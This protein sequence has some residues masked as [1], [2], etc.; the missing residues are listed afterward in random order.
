MR[1]FYDRASTLAKQGHYVDKIEIIVL[2]GTWSSYP[3]EYQ[4]EFCRDL[5][6]AANTFTNEQALRSGVAL[7][8]VLG[9]KRKRLSIGLE[10][11][12]NE[13]AECK[14]IGLTLETRPDK[15]NVAEVRRL[16][17]LGCTRVQIGVQHTDDR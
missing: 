1:Q 16:R 6:F 15:I 12:I 7:A 13:T 11:E 17:L 8:E 10:Q 9:E 5:F 14:I 3:R 4:E 2:G